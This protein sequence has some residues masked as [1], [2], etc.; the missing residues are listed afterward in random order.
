MEVIYYLRPDQ[1]FRDI[2][3]LQPF[4]SGNIL[5][6]IKDNSRP[7]YIFDAFKGLI[8]IYLVQ[9]FGRECQIEIHC[10]LFPNERYLLLP[11]IFVDMFYTGEIM[12]DNL[13]FPECIQLF[14][15][16]E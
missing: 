16:C 5:E 3:S 4:Y 15:R 2:S 10:S 9:Y 12:D 11:G 8:G 14:G 6:R 13:E 7:M 1:E